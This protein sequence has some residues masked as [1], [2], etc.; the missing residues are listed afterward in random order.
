MR[1]VRTGDGRVSI[2]TPCKLN[3]FLEVT[4]K[5]PDGYHDLDMIMEAIDLCDTIEAGRDADGIVLTTDAPG[6]PTDRGNIIAKAA[7]RFFAATGLP[8]RA[9]LHLRKRV[10]VGGGLGGG[11]ANG[12]GALFAL[13]ALYDAPLTYAEQ[14]RIACA[15]GSDVPFFLRGGIARC[16][17]RG[18]IMDALPNG[19]PR[20]FIVLVPPFGCGTAAVYANLNFPLTSPRS[21]CT[22]WQGSVEERI[23]SGAL[24][25]N[26]LEEPAVK[27][28]PELAHIKEKAREVGVEAHL[29]GSGACLFALLSN[30]VDAS[31]GGFVAKALAGLVEVRVAEN[32]P[33]W[34]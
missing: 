14:F 33:A 1:A 5:R 24:F 18:E 7:E 12:I 26:R 27:L 2:L 15:L 25:F 9:R 21:L 29:T 31:Y 28:R 32:L 19:R 3:L 11:S 23:R 17:G 10:P 8:P 22:I 34:G 13:M 6:I 16:R 30:D 20:R 4:G